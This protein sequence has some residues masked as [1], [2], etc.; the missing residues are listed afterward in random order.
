M[1]NDEPSLCTDLTLSMCNIDFKLPNVRRWKL[2]QLKAGGGEVR[3]ASGG[4]RG[5]RCGT[6][7][8]GRGRPGR[9]SEG[10]RVNLESSDFVRLDAVKVKE[11]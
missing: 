8:R 9:F 1:Y 11:S 5:C 6:C 2:D 10:A 3:H 7:R 4:E